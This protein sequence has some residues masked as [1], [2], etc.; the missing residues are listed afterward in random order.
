MTNAEWQVLAL[1]LRVATACVLVSVLPAALCAWFLVRRRSRFNAW[2]SLLTDLPLILPPVVTGTLL[3]VAFGPRGPLGSALARVG[4]AIP[5]TWW[6]AVVASAVVGFPL[7][8]RAM[9][10]GFG[11]VDPQLEQMA[12]T[13]GA[14]RWRT[15]QAVTV[16]LAWRGMLTGCILSFARSLGEFGATITLAANIPGETRT[17]PLAIYTA[18]ATPGGE[19]TAWRLVAISVALAV[20][21]LLV[22]EWL[23]GRGA[24][25]P[26]GERR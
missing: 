18:L 25:T 12:R 15:L 10:L 11:A 2:L 9:R 5:F 22:S 1:S 20:G 7:M 13:L 17:L 6:G 4:V 8:V 23:L 14:S 21:T 3:L 24:Q 26:V 19:G 16:P